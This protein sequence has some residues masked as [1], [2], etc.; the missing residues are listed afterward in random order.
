MSGYRPCV[1]SEM[2]FLDFYDLVRIA[3][4]ISRRYGLPPV[5]SEKVYRRC[6]SDGI[7]QPV[8]LTG[9]NGHLWV[10]RYYGAY[11]LK[12]DKL[13]YFYVTATHVAEEL[14]G[15]QEAA[16]ARGVPCRI[17]TR[18]RKELLAAMN[19]MKQSGNS[20]WISPEDF[21]SAA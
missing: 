12:T 19:E 4:D 14:T 21:P 10:D 11:W 13:Y 6:Y 5:P 18:I 15:W 1:I 16:Q 20:I 8:M 7:S 17:P 3:K 9:R 2:K